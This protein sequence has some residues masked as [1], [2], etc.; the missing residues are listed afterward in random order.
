MAYTEWEQQTLNH[1][2]KL[3]NELVTLCQDLIRIPSWNRDEPGEAEVAH[4]VGKTLETHGIHSE[5]FTSHPNIDNLVATW[6]VK[7]HQKRLLFNG[8]ADVVPPGEDWTINPFSAEIRDARIYGRGAMDMKGG[9]SA[10]T[11]AMCALRDLDIPLQGSIIL[12]VVGDEERQGALGTA[13][14]IKNI[15]EKIKVDA[16]IIAEPSGL[17][18][19]GQL[20]VIGEKG[21]VW[22]KVTT[23]GEKAHG[24]MPS[25][26]KNAVEMMFLLLQTLRKTKLPTVPSPFTREAV[27]AQ[28]AAALGM[29][30]ELVES[31]LNSSDATNSLAA[32]LTDMISTTMNIGTIQGG[33]A[34]NVVPD[35]CET[36]ID[37]RILPNQN[38]QEMIDFISTQATR[39]GLQDAYEMELIDAFKGT[40]VPNFE[41]DPVV[42]ILSE[43]SKEIVGPTIY[44]LVPYATDGRFLR[45]KGISSTVVYGPG[46]LRQAHTSDEWVAIDDL[47]KVTKVLAISA[48]RQLGVK[49]NQT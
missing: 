38:P 15:W 29:E 8:H 26:G 43:L 34:A 12:N 6:E 4:R 17:G 49:T 37:F 41:Q 5:Y 11:M 13:W 14:C 31:L 36:Q 10:M 45:E 18:Q 40:L 48:I 28:F 9:V 35:R 27:I 46:N 3:K 33:V 25:A 2:D 20:I 39:I 42:K 24:S 16:A 32:E 30:T 19:L 7:K 1:I 44:L 21:P 23:K 47:I 22:I